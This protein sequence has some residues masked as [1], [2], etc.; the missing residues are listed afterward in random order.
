MRSSPLFTP[1]IFAPGVFLLIFGVL[2]LVAP[3]LVRYLVALF[4]LF[5][6]GLFLF[7]AWQIIRLKRRLHTV[8]KQ[9]QII[10]HQDP[11]E[12]KVLFH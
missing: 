2:F 7:G 12:D 6:G 5:L 11:I 8:V 10:V 1:V 9:A 3:S 4:V